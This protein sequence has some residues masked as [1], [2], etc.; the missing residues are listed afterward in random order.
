MAKLYLVLLTVLIIFNVSF[1]GEIFILINLQNIEF[2]K[3]LEQKN[4]SFFLTD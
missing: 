3:K 2:L 1:Y 4:D